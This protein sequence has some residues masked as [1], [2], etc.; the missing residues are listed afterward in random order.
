MAAPVPLWRAQH[1]GAVLGAAGTSLADWVRSVSM[2]AAMSGSGQSVRQ[3]Q[4]RLRALTG[5]NRRRLE[6]YARVEDLS[7]LSRSGD[8]PLAHLALDGGFADQSDMGRMVRK[9]TGLRPLALPR[10]IA[11]D[12]APRACRLLGE[13]L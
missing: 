7:R 6:L 9:G 11:E 2:R 4:R 12:E 5:Q 8:A 1:P 10:A 13:W 3:A